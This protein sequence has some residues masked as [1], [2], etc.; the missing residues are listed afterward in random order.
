MQENLFSG[1]QTKRDANQPAQ[2]LGLARKL[3]FACSKSRYDTFQ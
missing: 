3:K 2:L 1:F